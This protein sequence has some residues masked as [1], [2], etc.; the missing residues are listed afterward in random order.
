M[1]CK[2][3]VIE[4]F[5]QRNRAARAEVSRSTPKRIVPTRDDRARVRS[6]AMSGLLGNQLAN[7]SDTLAKAS[8]HRDAEMQRI[9]PQ[10]PA[11]PTASAPVPTDFYLTSNAAAGSSVIASPSAP[12]HE[13]QTKPTLQNFGQHDIDQPKANIMG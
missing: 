10:P 1:A 13:P 2:N 6:I 5:E 7:I 11:A 9:R 4:R 12:L 3:N 8:Q